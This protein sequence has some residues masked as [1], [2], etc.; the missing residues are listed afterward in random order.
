MNNL[1]LIYQDLPQEIVE[2]LKD[3]VRDAN[4]DV[5]DEIEPSYLFDYDYILEVLDKKSEREVINEGLNSLR[6]INVSLPLPRYF[7]GQVRYRLKDENG[8]HESTAVANLLVEVSG[9]TTTNQDDNIT[10]SSY[11]DSTGKFTIK[12]PPEYC[13]QECITFTFKQRC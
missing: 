13:M 5:S 3:K 7:T 2:T 6:E 11:T 10:F 8:C 1:G 12:L 9:I 4:I